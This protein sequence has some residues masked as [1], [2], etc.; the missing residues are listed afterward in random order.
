MAVATDSHRDFLIPEDTV[1][2][3]PRFSIFI[4]RPVFILLSNHYTTKKPNLQGGA[5]TFE[6]INSNDKKHYP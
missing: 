5:E 6:V 3:C 4:E 1:L 2:Q